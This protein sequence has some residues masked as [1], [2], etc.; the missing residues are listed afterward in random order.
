LIGKRLALALAALVAAPAAAQQP[1]PPKL[2]V[3]V[4]V[5]Q[6]SSALFEQYR[7]QFTDGLARLALGSVFRNGSAEPAGASLGDLMKAHSPASRNVVVSGSRSG[8]DTMSGRSADQRWYW[9]GTRFETDIASAAVPPVVKKANAAIAAALAQPRPALQP[10]PFCE[11]KAK[12]G[13][14]SGRLGRAAGD[15]ATLAASPEL[16][17]D[18]LALAAGLVDAMQLGRRSQPDVISLDLS[19]TGNVAKAHGAISEEMCLQL[20]E[21]DREIGDFLSLLDRRGIDY[22]VALTGT[23]GNGGGPVPILFWRPDFRGATID[24]AVNEADMVATLGTL[25]DLPP[26][27]AP[28]GGRCLA[29]T[30]AFCPS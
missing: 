4:S 1:P 15:T 3:I 5:E 16:D 12:A 20:T 27:S 30:P 8:A 14:E 9:G 13:T 2:V 28:A 24:S 21:V 17:G 10:T 25:I 6:L 22:A 11:T 23:P 7:A 19:G 26:A 29:G 18:T